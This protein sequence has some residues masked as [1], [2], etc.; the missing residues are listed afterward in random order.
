MKIEDIE[1][2][3]DY[4]IVNTNGFSSK[5]KCLAKNQYYIKILQ[6]SVKGFGGEI[7]LMNEIE[8]NKYLTEIY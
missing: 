4:L 8:C 3:K 7:S 5:I 6:Y 1:I 2:G